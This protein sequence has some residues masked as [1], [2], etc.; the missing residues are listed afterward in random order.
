M[1]NLFE[2]IDSDPMFSRVHNL[3]SFHIY[4]SGLTQ[5]ILDYESTSVVTYEDGFQIRAINFNSLFNYNFR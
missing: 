3:D 2:I 5:I 4:F 1:Y